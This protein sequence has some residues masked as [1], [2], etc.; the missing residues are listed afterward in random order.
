MSTISDSRPAIQN[1]GNIC[2]TCDTKLACTQ[3]TN[4]NAM[5]NE[6]ATIKN[7]IKQLREHITYCSLATL[8]AI[9]A[10]LLASLSLSGPSFT[11]TYASP[12][13]C[14]ATD[15]GIEMAVLGERANVVLHTINQ[16]GKGYNT[17]AETVVCEL[18]SESTGNK[19]DCNVKKNTGNQYEISYQPTSRGRHQLHIK[20][21]GEHIKGSPFSIY[22]VRK[23]GDPIDT[24]YDAHRYYNRL[25]FNK[26]TG[27]II[28]TVPSSNISL[29]NLLF[30]E[31][32]NSFGS[33]GTGQGQFHHICDH[34]VDADGNILVTDSSNHYIQKFDSNGKYITHEGKHGT[35]KYEL[36]SPCGI[37]VHP[38]NGMIY[39]SE[40]SNH[41]IQVLD[42][43]LKSNDTFGTQGSKEGQFNKPKDVAFDS[44]GNL[45]VADTGN[46]RIQ[47]FTAKGDFLRQIGKEGER[48]GELRE[49]FAITVD[50][51]DIV[52]V[53]DTINRRIS[54]FTADGKFLTSLGRMENHPKKTI[55]PRGIAVDQNGIVYTTSYMYYIQEKPSIT[56]F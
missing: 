24:F 13:D 48:D 7:E 42:H 33:H 5:N 39:V 2:Q 35:S 44:T 41:R 38:H 27:E 52:Y 10:I 43:N 29:F 40:I 20:V 50:S 23:F 8:V 22:V 37:E 14:F 19:V 46:H 55:A 9:T 17:K 28:V 11:N 12:K 32:S 3:C 6:W 31:T 34:A 54:M 30:Q 18:V 56:M 53:T 16:E 21:E 45:Y 47:V 26:R 15:R 49:P 36:N 51:D 25:T 1:H 4:A